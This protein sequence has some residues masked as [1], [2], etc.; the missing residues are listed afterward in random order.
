MRTVLALVLVSTIL[1]HAPL[2]AQET[3]NE[4]AP[5]GKQ[6][7]S[8]ADKIDEKGSKKDK[9]KDEDKPPE[10]SITHHSVTIDGKEVAYTATARQLLLEKDGGEDKAYIFFVA[11]TRD[12]VEDSDKRPVTFCFNGGPG[13]S[14]VW[15]HLGALGPRRVRL[16]VDASRS[17]PPHHVIENPFSMLDKT[18]LVFIDPVSTGYS[19]PA[20]GE[21]KNQFH[22]YEQD[23]R[24]VGQFIHDYVT[25]YGRWGSPK[26]L[27]GESYGGL[28]AAGLSGTLQDRYYMYLSGI[29]LVS[30]VVDFQTVSSY[31]EN[32]VAFASFLPS[33]ATTAWYHGALDEEL[34][35]KTVEEVA[36]EARAFARDIYHPVLLWGD[37]LPPDRRAAVIGQ[38]ARL[39]GLSEDYLD[40]SKL[41]VP[42]SMF[43]KELLRERKLVVGRYD[44]RYTG[45]DRDSAGANWEHDPS[46]AA[47]FGAFT[48]A[49]NEYLHS[50]LKYHDERVYEI[51][52]GNVQPW[53]FD[54]FDN[55]YVNA[56]ETLRSAMARNPFLKV[57]AACGYYDLATP[58]YGM[59]Y[60][61]DHL[62]LPPELR[63]NFSIGYYEA[64]HMMYIHE[65]S[66]R[67]LRSDL[68]KFYDSALTGPQVIP[69]QR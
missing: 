21:N 27:I 15:L 28:R 31:P 18:D 24:S 4:S 61:R 47:V 56:S 37:S 26:F 57:F 49:I 34:Q 60:T 44:S 7:E 68:L 12:D 55:R 65:P 45:W 22:G 16:P 67:K 58:F 52:T 9:Q 62:E 32:D 11:Y 53:S 36:G 1:C 6:E 30:A 5:A 29:V 40:L 69:N 33:Y 39:T 41:R 8:K 14:S 43:G 35:S 23:L 66:L 20:K 3:E 51:L 38:M 50:G 59:E 19:R 54:R 63:D 13:S 48:S 17:R 46:A 64:G 42:V 2:R 25:E 10:P